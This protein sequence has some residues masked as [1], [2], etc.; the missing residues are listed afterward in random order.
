MVGLSNSLLT[1][2]IFGLIGRCA[3]SSSYPSTYPFDNS[4][5]ESV[6]QSI[7]TFTF[8][9]NDPGGYILQAINCDYNDEQFVDQFATGTFYSRFSCN[10]FRYFLVVFYDLPDAFAPGSSNCTLS[11]PLTLDTPEANGYPAGTCGDEF[12]GITSI[13]F[14]PYSFW[15]GS[16]E[17]I[18]NCEPA[19]EA[20]LCL[21]LL[22]S[23]KWCIEHY[24]SPGER[25]YVTPCSDTI[26]VWA[27]TCTFVF[28][29]TNFGIEPESYWNSLTQEETEY[30]SSVMF[31][32]DRVCKPYSYYNPSS[33]SGSVML[34][35]TVAFAAILNLVFFE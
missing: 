18:G 32:E 25:T 16:Y 19:S 34:K 5:S 17:E 23:V 28:P 29:M 20:A 2:G 26:M 14:E 15:I 22:T 31:N 7:P 12:L 27:S 35:Y 30:M 6:P 8:D 21:Q 4:L 11:Q 33:T 10:T 1:F 13:N 9:S 24:L 3:S